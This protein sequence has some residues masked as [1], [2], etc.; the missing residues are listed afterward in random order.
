[1]DEFLRGSGL[2]GKALENAIAT[3]EKEDIERVED[4]RALRDSG[5]LADIGFK[6]LALSKIT[7]SL[8]AEDNKEGDNTFFELPNQDKFTSD[9][10]Y[11]S[12]GDSK[13]VI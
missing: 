11:F 9:V 7:L 10:N 13:V 5:D 2:E 12:F 1:M 6:R 4:L 3:C 8:N